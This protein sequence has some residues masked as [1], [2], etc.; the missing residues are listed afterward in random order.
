MVKQFFL[1]M[2]SQE[3]DSSNNYRNQTNVLLIKKKWKKQRKLEKK[4]IISR[5]SWEILDILIN[6]TQ[7]ITKQITTTLN[8][9]W[10]QEK[11][12]AEGKG[13]TQEQSK[14]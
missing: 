5:K 12:T 4:V 14:P 11:F 9:P 3:Q 2:P 6:L 10:R 1:I 7:D 13:K 8:F